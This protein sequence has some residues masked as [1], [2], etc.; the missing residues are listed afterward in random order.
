MAT[1]MRV[2]LT[3]ALVAAFA[4]PQRR[5]APPSRV[6]R[7]ATESRGKR[8]L[9]YLAAPPKGLKRAVTYIRDRAPDAQTTKLTLKE[10]VHY[11]VATRVSGAAVAK[12]AFVVS[13]C[14]L[15]ALPSAS[16]VTTEPKMRGTYFSEAALLSE[17]SDIAFSATGTG[18]A[19]VGTLVGASVGDAVVGT[20]VGACDGAAVVG[21]A[22]V[23]AAV[24][25]FVVHGNAPGVC[26]TTHGA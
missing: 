5:L 17:H 9:R 21:A 3:A 11:F 24:G 19:T 13:L 7:M 8:A 14:W 25:A 12:V 15:T 2:L 6:L 26:S 23:G 22:V 20:L 10:R 4:P 16:V 18:K 1:R